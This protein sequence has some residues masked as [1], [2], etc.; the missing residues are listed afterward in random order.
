[1]NIGEIRYGLDYLKRM[2]AYFSPFHLDNYAMAATA[3]CL[4]VC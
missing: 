3:G 2:Q 1:M 4:R